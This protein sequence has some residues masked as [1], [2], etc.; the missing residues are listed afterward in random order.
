MENPQNQM[1]K[2]MENESG[3]RQAL[4]PKPGRKSA[5]FG[6]AKLSVQP[7]FHLRHLPGWCHMGM[8]VLIGFY[9]NRII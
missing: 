7:Y 8:A 1:E 3:F 9:T 2:N 6:T 4:N 5:G